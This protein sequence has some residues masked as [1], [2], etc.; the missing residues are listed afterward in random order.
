MFVFSRRELTADGIERTFAVYHLAPFLL[1]SLLLEP[2]SVALPG[3]RRASIQLQRNDVLVIR[4]DRE[5]ST[6]QPCSRPGD[7]A[8]EHKP[9]RT[10]CYRQGW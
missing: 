5:R 3:V 7:S 6:P 8:R 2:G 4:D 9:G 10:V 1:T